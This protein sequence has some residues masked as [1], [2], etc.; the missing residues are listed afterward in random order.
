MKFDLNKSIGV[1]ERTPTVL[2]VMLRGLSDEWTK[3]N[4]GEGTWS[5]FD[6]VGHLIHGEKTDWMVRL[7]VILSKDG[8]KTFK[9]F[10]RFAQFEN[11]NGKSLPELLDEFQQ[12]REK[13]LE[14]LRS[15]NLEEAHQNQTGIHPAFG[16]VSLSQLLATWVV[17][18]L[19][20]LAQI[21]R[22]MARQYHSAVGPW[23]AYLRILQ[24]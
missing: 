1:L 6:V 3:V 13:N 15:K 18:D 21:C 17:H 10:D 14:L 11:S 7:E 4:E 23:T 2:N 22:V 19:N 12:L 24:S 9:P 16:E 5:A 20:H 8:E